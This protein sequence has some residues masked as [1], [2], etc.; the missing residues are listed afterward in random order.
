MADGK[1]VDLQ[2]IEKTILYPL[3]GRYTESKKPNGLIRDDKCIELVE[4]NGIDLA[5]VEKE[6]HAVN[7]LELFYQPHFESTSVPFS[8]EGLHLHFTDIYP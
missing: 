1:F 3:W 8:T 5:A 7:R 6:Q 2:G 4:K